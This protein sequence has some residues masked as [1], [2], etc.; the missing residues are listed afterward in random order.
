MFHPQNKTHRINIIQNEGFEESVFL[1]AQVAA[2]VIF[3]QDQGVSGGFLS[4]VQVWLL[5]I[6][7]IPAS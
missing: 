2:K 5:P 1:G 6:H 4:R 3:V 7:N